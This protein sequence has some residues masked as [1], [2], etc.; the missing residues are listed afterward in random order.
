MN[1]NTSIE[2]LLLLYMNLQCSFN[3]I[4][5]IIFKLVIV[6]FIMYTVEMKKVCLLI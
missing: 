3:Y 2:L 1:S 6:T 5:T 4:M